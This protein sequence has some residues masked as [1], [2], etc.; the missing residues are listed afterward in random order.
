MSDV[1]RI[2]AIAV[3]LLVLLRVAIGWQLLY[4]GLWKIDTLSTPK[5]WTAAGYLKNAEGPLRD[6]FRG[7]A[8][9]P[10]DLDWLNYDVVA[11]RWDGWAASAKSHLKLDGRQKD[12]LDRLLNGAADYR[13]ELDA[14]PEGVK[15]EDAGG[16]AKKVIS[17]DPAAKRLIVSKYR[18]QPSEKDKLLKLVAGQTGPQ[19]EKYK[20]AIEKVFKA[21]SGSLS[22][23]EKLAA[24]VRGNPDVVGS[25]KLQYVGELAQYRGMLEEYNK[26]RANAKTAFEWDHL[27]YTWKDLQSRRSALAGP[28]KAMESEFQEKAL[29]QIG[30][31]QLKRGAV[32]NPWTPLRI[33][34]MLTI[35]GLT[36]LGICL[37]V[38][39]F[40]RFSALSAAFMLFSF[41]MV[42]PPFP[43][44][45]V[46][47]GPEHSF[48]VNKNLI[49]VVALIAIAATSSGIWFGLDGILWKRKAAKKAAK[50]GVKAAA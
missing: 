43:G 38:G 25:E 2:S 28:I 27:S 35:V 15:L 39:L 16:F 19:V 50:Q 6:V 11:A 20:A 42:W 10:D 24:S 36:A 14:L 40:T 9:D 33:S 41:Y 21:A 7:M 22:Y 31:E 45:P 26:D 32:P 23:K 3:A 8:G 17:F 29:G 34:N 37:I 49:E 44:V 47:P 1:R 13:A 4:E 48:I 12:R 30:A 5:P 18:L 46:A